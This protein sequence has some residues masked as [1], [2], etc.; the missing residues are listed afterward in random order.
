MRGA[1][2]K[3]IVAATLLGLLG[4]ASAYALRA[5]VGVVVVDATARVTP[6]ALPAK[7]AAPVRLTSTT[8][9]ST[10]DGSPVPSLAKLRFQFDR[11]GSIHTRGVPVCTIAKLEGTTPA[12]ARKRCAGALVGTGVAT[13]EVRIG[14]AAPIK[15]SS[16]LS[17]F[18]AP[19]RNGRPSLIAH[20][21]E[22]VPDRETLLVP[23]AIEPIKHG[24]Y[25][26]RVEIELPE[27]ADGYGAATLA[28]ATLGRTYERHGRRFGYVSARCAGSR[29]QVYGTASFSNGD[30]FPATLAPSCR[31]QR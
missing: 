2:P 11:H 18:N 8:R 21:Y 6:R 23:I 31:V 24:R 26:Y 28:K 25:G 30:F 1:L 9:V 14:E 15:I 29:L 27:I 5:E 10:K 7:G 19:R 16:P 17:F 13:A 12:G 4:A 3:L 20:A 22:T